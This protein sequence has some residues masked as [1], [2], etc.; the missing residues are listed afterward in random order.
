[1]TEYSKRE[2]NRAGK[3]LLDATEP[4]AESYA[5]SVVNYWR[6]LHE[7]ALQRFFADSSE[8]LKAN[9]DSVLAGRIKKFDTVVNKL[10]R[11]NNP[12]DLATMHDIAGCRIVVPDMETLNIVCDQLISSP[13]YKKSK[14]Y[15]ASPKSNG[16]RC[17]HLFFAYNDLPCGKQLYLELQVRTR[18]QHAWATAVEMYDRIRKTRLKFGESDPNASI[19]F[20]RWAELISQIESGNTPEVEL[21]RASF[22][23]VDSLYDHKRIKA[24]LKAACD[25]TAIVGDVPELSYND[26]CLISFYFDLQTITLEK[27]EADQAVARYFNK[28]RQSEEAD[29]VLVRGS[30][31]EQLKTMY[32]NYF[33]DIS[34]FL[35]L[36]EQHPSIFA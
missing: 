8:V 35:A 36:I 2:V 15:I 33:G 22:P 17:H 9:P 5:C 32:P 27:I 34:D 13:N 10:K 21:I 30:S 25:S 6:K 29:F 20:S 18:Q 4:T 12:S 14:D 23:N 19:F 26:Y 3:T 28:E 1:M 7:E 11:P 24:L 16:Y 31:I